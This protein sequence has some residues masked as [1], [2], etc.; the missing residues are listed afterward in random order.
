MANPPDLRNVVR[1]ERTRRGWSQEDLARRSGLSRTGVSAIE[2]G[3]LVPSAAGALA[4]ARAMGCRFEDLFSLPTAVPEWAW[5]PSRTPC[6]FWRAEVSGRVWLFPVEETSPL[7]LV[8]H[9]G[10]KI[11]DETLTDLDPDS[12]SLDRSTL[13]IACCDPAVGLLAAELARAGVRLIV[14]PRSSR[15]ALELLGKGLVHAAGLHLAR[16]ET[17][18]KDALGPGYVLVRA[19]EWE[20]GVTFSSSTRIVSLREAT[21]RRLRWVGREPGSGARQCLDE[22]LGDRPSPRRTAH[23]HRAVAEAVRAGWADAGVCHRLASEEAGLSFL[24]ARKEAHDLCFAD[25][26][27]DDPRLKALL[28]ALRSTSY[29]KRLGELPGFDSTD[30]GEIQ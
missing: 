13:V 5:T 19:A 24:E 12:G 2:T 23:N 20:E 27:R 16:N 14:L 15:S 9:D 22:I 17:V 18:V 11:A 30:T 6:R 28:E 3:R 21:R 8:P 10:V 29:R 1:E 7:G 25:S 4:L 26:T